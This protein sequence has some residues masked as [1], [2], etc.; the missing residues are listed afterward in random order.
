VNE[1]SLVFGL[2]YSIR[3]NNGGLVKKRGGGRVQVRMPETL[4]APDHH[5]F[6]RRFAHTFLVN[7]LGNYWY[8]SNIPI[9]AKF[10][11][12]LRP[13]PTSRSP[14]NSPTLDG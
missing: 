6:K 5:S 9:H 4:L 7:I 13:L 3:Y 8:R 14:S 12:E 1:S 10:P 11:A 2:I